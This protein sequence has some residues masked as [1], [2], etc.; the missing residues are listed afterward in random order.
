MATSKILLEIDQP[1]DFHSLIHSHGWMSLLPNL[2][3]PETDGFS[4]IEELPSG[5]VV[6]LTLS[7]I[8]NTRNTSIQVDIL[9]KGKLSKAD[10]A[11][12]ETRVG[13][14]LRIDENF[15]E[16]YKLCRQKGQPWSEMAGGQGRLLRSPTLFED[17]VKVIC[18][19]N[20]QWGGTMRM[21]REMVTTFGSPLPQQPELK[22][23]PIPENI[24]S[25]S[26]A[27]FEKNLR[28]GYRTRYVYDLACTVAENPDFMESF[29][30]ES[31][32]TDELKKKLLEIKGIGNYA[33]ASILMLLGRYDNI[34]VDTVFR[35][36]MRVKYY[37]EKEFDLSQ[38]V[39]IYDDWGKWKYLAYWFELLDHASN[40]E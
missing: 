3:I 33:A 32:P 20:I 24:A 22:A 35:D 6:Q 29:R 23:F 30:D 39:A 16:F 12:I 18:T 2:Y 15:S 27:D 17:M 40:Q 13:H 38:A 25:V 5:K 36:L 21:V 37:G 28:L 10:L 1:F 8:P 11:A 26:F 31:L 34:P 7:E 9:H 4:R 14:M 19:T